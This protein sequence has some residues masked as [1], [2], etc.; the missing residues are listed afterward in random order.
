MVCVLHKLNLNAL[1]LLIMPGLLSETKRRPIINVKPMHFKTTFTCLKKKNQKSMHCYSSKQCCQIESAVIGTVNPIISF[2]ITHK[3]WTML[4]L[5]WL[6]TSLSLERPRFN[7]RPVHT[8]HVDKMAVRQFSSKHSG[9]SCQYQSTNAPCSCS[10]ISQMLYS[11]RNW[12]C[13]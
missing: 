11:L 5:R 13:H 6:A 9:F 3:T 7:P 4:W 1:T 2:N 10:H 12:Q 8:A